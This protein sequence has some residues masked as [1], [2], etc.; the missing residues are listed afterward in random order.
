MEGMN[1]VRQL[2]YKMPTHE[3]ETVYRFRAARKHITIPCTKEYI[4]RVFTDRKTTVN[5]LDG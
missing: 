1:N 4:N 2:P 3:I 5:R